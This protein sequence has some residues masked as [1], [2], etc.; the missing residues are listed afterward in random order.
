MS[1]EEVYERIRNSQVN[2]TQST[3]IFLSSET[4]GVPYSLGLLVSRIPYLS[5]NVIYLTIKYV[6]IPYVKPVT[7]FE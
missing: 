1:E 6:H 2:R 7:K 3:S 4:E 5:E